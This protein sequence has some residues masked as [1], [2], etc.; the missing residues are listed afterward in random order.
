M[1]RFIQE[2]PTLYNQTCS[3]VLTMPRTILLDLTFAWEKAVDIKCSSL[4]DQTT[5]NGVDWWTAV[6]PI[7]DKMLSLWT[8]M[9]R[10]WPK[11]LVSYERP[12]GYCTYL[13]HYSTCT[14]W[15]HLI[16]VLSSFF[17]PQCW[18]LFLH[19]MTSSLQFQDFVLMLVSAV[20]NHP[21]PLHL[22]FL[23]C[24]KLSSSS[25]DSLSA[26][27]KTPLPFLG[28]WA[29]LVLEDVRLQLFWD[30]RH[31]PLMAWLFSSFLA[32]IQ[33]WHLQLTASLLQHLAFLQVSWLKIVE[34][35]RWKHHF[36]IRNTLT[37]TYL[38]PLAFL[39]LADLI[40]CWDTN[41]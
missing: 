24:V 31:H 13:Q 33:V 20:L 2:G 3:N 14:L 32:W 4:F 25:L 8:K 17:P 30:G 15:L 22:N 21:C 37:K 18:L 9:K 1:L 27:V 26:T 28:H 40:W 10:G 5:F 23:E 35:L 16:S 7:N 12:Q 19:L 11:S 38:P 36:T 39:L 6:H 41:N 34:I 29:W